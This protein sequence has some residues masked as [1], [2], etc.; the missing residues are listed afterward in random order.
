I[1][2]PAGTPPDIVADMATA[3]KEILS[4][5]ATAAQLKDTQH[6]TLLL[7]DGADFKTFFDKQVADWGKVVKDNN[8]KA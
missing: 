1:F 6:M 2:V 8:I 3:L 7:Q 4:E 5:P